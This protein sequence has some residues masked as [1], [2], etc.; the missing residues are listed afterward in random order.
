MLNT[1]I[2]EAGNRYGKW[3]VLEYAGYA[4]KKGTMWLC[5]CDCGTIRPVL[6][7]SLRHGRSKGCECRAKE[8]NSKR[9]L[10]HEAG[11]KYGKLTVVEYAGI[12]KGNASWLCLCDCGNTK[13]VSGNSLRDGFVKSCGCIPTGPKPLP[14][15]EG[16]FNN[17]YTSY[18]HGAKTRGIYWEIDKDLFRII[19]GQKCFYCGIEP[20]QKNISSR[21]DVFVYNGIDRYD[22]SIG[23]IDGNVVACCGQCNIAKRAYTIEEW[24]EWINRLHINLEKK[25]IWSQG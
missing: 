2:D 5:K 19:V 24:Y 22:N 23:Y 4:P 13:T 6:G 9:I 16:S 25:G 11:N 20:L 3:S 7:N 21:G 10:K 1:R 17:L 14:D 8:E 15:G 18:Q 12:I